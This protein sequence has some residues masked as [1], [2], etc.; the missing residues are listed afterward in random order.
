[1]LYGTSTP[2]KMP[3]KSESFSKKSLTRPITL[4][5]LSTR[6]CFI[7]MRNLEK[8]CGNVKRLS[9]GG[10]I[11]ILLVLLLLRRAVWFLTGRYRVKQFL[12]LQ[13]VRIKF[14]TFPIVLKWPS[15]SLALV[16]PLDSRYRCCVPSS[17]TTSCCTDNVPRCQQ[18]TK[19]FRRENYLK[20]WKEDVLQLYNILWYFFFFLF[21]FLYQL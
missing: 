13:D 14:V 9:A 12:F 21:P 17:C 8:S 4:W 11:N 15:T 19:D 16:S 2:H 3:T 5:T 1:M 20:A 7:S 6:K 18:L 10:S